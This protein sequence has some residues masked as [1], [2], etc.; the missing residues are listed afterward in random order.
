MRSQSDA[1]LTSDFAGPSFQA[2]WSVQPI[3]TDDLL[4]YIQLQ[5]ICGS[6]VLCTLRQDR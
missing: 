4:L 5:G 3:R 6:T 1:I 2:R